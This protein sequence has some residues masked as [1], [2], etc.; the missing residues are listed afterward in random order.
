VLVILTDRFISPIVRAAFSPRVLLMGMNLDGPIHLQR[1]GYLTKERNKV[2]DIGPQNIYRTRIDQIRE[3]VS[4]QGQ[5]VSD[6]KLK[7]EIDRLVY[8]STP[9]PEERTTLFSEI[10]DLTDIEYNSIDVCPGLKTEILDLNFDPLPSHM[11]CHYDVVFNFGTTEHIFNQWN[12]FEVIHNALKPGGVAYHQLPASG[13]LDHGYYCY[14]P[15]FFREM[16]AANRYDVI[17][18]FVTPAGENAIDRLKISVRSSKSIFEPLE[19]LAQNN[20]IPQLNIHAILRKTFDAPFR[21][22][23]E[24][25]TAHAPVNDA[26]VSRYSNG[27]YTQTVPSNEIKELKDEIDA[28]YASRSWRVTKPLRWLSSMVSSR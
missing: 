7:S 10:T 26:M 16:A 9:R 23:L 3:F 11:K 21:C 18:L 20:R 17:D 19:H 15:L 14:T 2:L 4:N 8:F 1:L 25:A 6:E 28:I 24:I 27:S 5:A 22:G 13:Y 12:C